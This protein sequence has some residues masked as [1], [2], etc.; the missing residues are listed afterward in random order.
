MDNMLSNIFNKLN[1]FYSIVSS[2]IT[3]HR[4]IKI[5]DHYYTVG[6]GDAFQHTPGS[7]I[8]SSASIT[9]TAFVILSN[10]AVSQPSTGQGMNVVSTSASDT[11]NGTGVQQ[12]TIEYFTVPSGTTGWIKKSEVV[13]LNGVTPVPTVAVD[14]YRINRV[15]TNRVGTNGTAVGTITV[16]DLTNTTLFAQIDIGNNVF[17][18]AIHYVTKG[19]MAVLS[20]TMVGV[21]SNGG[22]IF[23]WFKTEEDANGNTVTV[24][25][26]SI[27]MNGPSALD[28]S[29]NLPLVV[30]NPN[31]KNISIGLAVKART[32]TQSS[33]GT[34]RFHDAPV[35]S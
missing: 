34:L 10:A 28:R 31:G 24:G 26:L 19:E 8:G 12:I 13:T 21:S 18:R 20:D 29:F 22:V 5:E 25:Q 11:S 17:E 3:Q 27:E 33:T 30:S 32:G 1:K 4:T 16:K 9:T 6:V 14:I 7:I 35:I 2:V 23:R 15:H